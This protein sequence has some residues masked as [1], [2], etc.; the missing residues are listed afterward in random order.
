MSGVRGMAWESF[1]SCVS[2]FPMQG[3][4]R[5]ESSRLSDMTNRLACG[6]YHE[7]NLM[8]LMNG[9]SCIALIL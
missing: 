2:D 4:H 3:V 7:D 8:E 1:V 5:F 9:L 6:R